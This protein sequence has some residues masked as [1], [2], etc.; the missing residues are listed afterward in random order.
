MD[1]PIFFADYFGTRTLV[2]VIAIVHVWINHAFAVGMIPLVVGVEWWAHRTNRP[3]WDALAHKILGVCF[4]V[5]TSVGALTG[6]GIWLSTAL[7]NPYAMGSLLRVFYW[8]W[9]SEWVVFVA[10]VSLI[11]VYYL[12]WKRLTGQRKS[13]HIRIGVLLGLM[14]WLTMAIIVAILGFMMNPGS[15]LEQRDLLTGFTNPIY[16]PQLLFRTAA[17][18][19]MAGSLALALSIAFTDRE[20]SLQ[21]QAIKLFSGWSLFWLVPTLIGGLAY[22]HVI[23]QAMLDNMPVA[24]GTQAWQ[25]LYGKLVHLTVLAVAAVALFALWGLWQPLRAN[26]LVWI[27]PVLLLTGLMGYF[28]RTREFIRKPYAIGYYMYANGIRVDEVPHLVKTGVLANCS[29]TANRRVTGQNKEGAGRDLFMVLCSRCHTLNGINSVKDNLAKMYPGQT[30][31]S[32]A[33]IESFLKNIHGARSFMPPFIGNAD[34][35][36]ALAAV[37]GPRG[38]GRD[39]PPPVAVAAIDE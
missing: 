19:T 14:S 35:R 20:S 22:H 24:F 30:T 10:E 16:L 33:A 13:R 5:T 39:I 6:V 27:V 8:A 28:E 11:L 2:G 17:A 29:W 21:T 4:I 9:F 12:T 23:P 15:W 7:V 37:L 31:W 1:L 38:N 36:A 32:S 26:P 3:E 18:L 25:D 34:E